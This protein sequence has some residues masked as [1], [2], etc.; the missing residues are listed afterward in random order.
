MADAFLNTTTLS[1]QVKTAYNR[2]ADFALRE[3]P[4]FDQ[5]ATVKAGNLTNPGTPVSFYLYDD[6]AQATS[7]LAETSDPD[8]VSITDSQITVT[9]AE[10][11]NLT[12]ASLKVR[13]D[14]FLVGFDPDIASIV[15][16]NMAD[17]LDAL[18]QAA[19]DGG[20]NEDYVGQA[21]EGAITAANKLVA[22]EVRQK[23]AELRGASVAGVA[24][25]L[26]V[27]V[28]HPDTAYDLK[29]ET[30][31]GAWIAPHQYVDTS[32]I[33]N[34]EIGT[35]GGFRF[36]ESA[37]ATI[38]TDGGAS[39]V[40]TYTNYF[41]GAQALAKAEP[42]PGHIVIGPVVDALMRVRPVGWYSYVGW[43]TYREA[44]VQRLLSASSIGDNA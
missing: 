30:G 2:V 22:S 40:D 6:L 43:D 36:I 18:A 27:A 26:Y 31:D 25:D 12:K 21:T 19:L 35:F 17:S 3:R 42:I 38:N 1:D 14:T 13:T 44:A 32:N 8:A 33:Y 16:Y 4:V 9:P 11:G 10:H 39:T 20:G 7:A 41:L 5:F 37:R 29:S 23:R 34:D 24:G 28:I 15:A